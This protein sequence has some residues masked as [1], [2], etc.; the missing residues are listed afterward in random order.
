MIRIMKL[1][2]ILIL[3][4]GLNVLT[5]QT[6]KVQSITPLTSVEQGEFYFPQMHPSGR[7]VICTGPGYRGLYAID[8]EDQSLEEI[9]A[10]P[11]A[12]YEFVLSADGQHVFYRTSTYR[13]PKRYSS[14]L[15][16]NMTTKEKTILEAEVRDLSTPQQVA[17]GSMVYVSQDQVKRMRNTGITPNTESLATAPAVFIENRKIA[18]YRGNE[19][20]LL[21]PF[22][23]G[24]YIWPSVSPDGE[25]LLFTLA[26]QGTFI[27][28]L[29]GNVLS[30]LGR[31]NAP[32]WSP[33]GQWVVF[34]DDRDDGRVFTDSEIFIIKADGSEKIQLTNTDD[35]IEMYPR[36]G[37]DN[38]TIVYASDSGVVY[39]MKLT[40]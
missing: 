6:L 2:C 22:G 16:L 27:S 31:A 39:L 10:D 9:S 4:G 33:D 34:M 5:A 8:L 29:D 23:E 21:E 15:Q 40:R 37:T 17:D 28:D 11:G 36:W 7:K 12:G 24:I 3:L 26:G 32:Q 14:L 25:R 30:E 13:G 19:K 1:F 35:I 18:L 20:M 38:R